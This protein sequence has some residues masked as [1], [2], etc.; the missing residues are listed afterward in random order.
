VG[1][2][3]AAHDIFEKSRL[4]FMNLLAA[5][6]WFNCLRLTRVGSGQFHSANKIRS[7]IGIAIPLVM[8]SVAGCGNSAQ[9]G[10]EAKTTQ[11]AKNIDAPPLLRKWCSDCHAPPSPK[12]HRAQE[13][14]NV[15]A[16]MQMHR[17]TQGLAKINSQ[18]LENL[19]SYLQSHAKP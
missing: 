19:V 12:S 5:M 6:Q 9:P 13:W 14:L 4:S 1:Y 3:L 10:N 7:L 17:S 8:I 2:S 16:V 15:V 18:D 11:L